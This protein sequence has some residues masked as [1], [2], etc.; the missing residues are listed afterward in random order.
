MEQWDSLGE[1]QLEEEAALISASI[2]DEQLHSLAGSTDLSTVNFLQMAVD[3]EY[4]PLGT[5]GERLPVLEQLKLNGSSIPSIRFLGTS[6]S[7]LRVLWICRCG[8]SG[9]EG[10]SALPELQ[11]LYV[12]FNEVSAL[13]CITEAERLE[14]LDLEANAIADMEQVEWVSLVPTLQEVTLRGNPVCDSSDTFRAD[15]IALLPNVQLLDD[16]PT[17]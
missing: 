13:S 6:L 7:K 5:L 2:T 17:S 1:D 15:A 4:V 12:A 8:L 9:L 16:Q 10:L 11:E 14:I 3:S